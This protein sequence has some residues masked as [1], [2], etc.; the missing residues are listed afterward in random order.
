MSDQR[1]P[2]SPL[3]DAL[4]LFFRNKP[5]VAAAI[6]IFLLACVAVSGEF[7]TGKRPSP[8]EVELIK[9]SLYIGDKVEVKRNAIALS[10]PL[11]TV[12][13]EKLLPPFSRGEQTGNFY[14]LGTD[15]LGRDVLSRLWAGSTISLTIGFLSVGIMALLGITLGGIAGFWG[16]ERVRL[17]FFAMLV[18]ALGGT[19]AWGADFDA[20]AWLLFGLSGAAFLF[21]LVVVVLGR[22]WGALAV[23]AVAAVLFASV[24]GYNQYI[25]RTDPNGR[26]MQQARAIEK[27]ARATLNDARA[28]GMDVKKIDDKAEGAPDLAW[29]IRGQADVE[30]A[31]A[32][33]ALETARFGVIE[34]EAAIEIAERTIAEREARATHLDGIDRGERAKQERAT[35]VTEREGLVRLQQALP[36]LKDALAVAELELAATQA[37][38]ELAL[39]DAQVA[40]AGDNAARRDDLAKQRPALLWAVRVADLTVKEAQAANALA[41]RER[42]IANQQKQI[43][44]LG[45]KADTKPATLEAE[46]KKLDTLREGVA[47][48]KAAAE[49]AKT[50]L[51]QARKDAEAA[52]ALS[53]EQ[54]KE[55]GELKLQTHSELLER[56]AEI[57]RDYLDRFKT[58]G[59]KRFKDGL[60]EAKLLSKHWR[61]PV[62]RITRH[63]IAATILWLG[64]LVA[65]LV[66]AGTAQGA[67]QDI[68]GPLQKLFLPTMTVDDLVMRFTEIMITIPTLFLILAV[69]ALFDRDVYIVM[70]VIGLTGWMGMTRF[71]RAEILSLREQDFIQAA[72]AL[73]VSDFRII[74]RH[75]VPNAISPVLV[76]ATIGVAGAVL[77]ESTL[78]FL[79]IG[80]RAD[81]PTWGQIL[82]DGRAYMTDAG[83]LMVIP[84]FAILVTVLSFN[85]LG[86]GLREAFNPKLRGR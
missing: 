84:G 34:Q 35:L 83:W 68:K 51:E 45:A 38:R 86:E 24:N 10:D 71:V 52:K 37:R 60:I 4:R 28:Y 78:S 25:E 19:I 3:R 27:L 17:P 15:H 56:R 39:H 76:A 16:R 69:L 53:D 6:A 42:A 13:D 49:K 21:Q 61:L 62:Y 82:N 44:D 32:R 65:V 8:E 67:I 26:A 50:G 31:V 66:I 41:S 74:W 20:L 11:E 30:L 48:L 23:F 73:G 55:L 64:M 40:A 29:R 22:R 47:P 5:A 12:L 2:S 36:D 63:F 14:L 18:F 77:A 72:R 79:G 9:E 46:R 54:I 85:L 57:R 80:A 1:K 75:L 7:L 58:E 81:Q 70:A 59:D 33:L 43:S